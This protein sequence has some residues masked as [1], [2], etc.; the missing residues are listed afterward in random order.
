MRKW[1]REEKEAALERLDK[2]ESAAV[3]A[4]SIGTNADRLYNWRWESKNTWK[5]R[6]TPKAKP[7]NKPTTHS[8]RIIA[9]TPPTEKAPAALDFFEAVER[10]YRALEPMDKKMRSRVLKAA[11]LVLGLEEEDADDVKLAR[12]AG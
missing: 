7:K 11:N 1:T 4:K 8:Q 5:A 9:P 12:I 2:G 10:I 6:P 3:V